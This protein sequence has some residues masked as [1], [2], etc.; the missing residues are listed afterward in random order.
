MSS[1]QSRRD[2]VAAAAAKLETTTPAICPGCQSPSISTT[3]KS[4]DVQSYWRCHSCGEIW[5][6][7]RRQSSR[8]GA[9]SWR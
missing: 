2:E 9:Q 6:V 3:T 4:P 7:S 8:F 1:Y 5:N